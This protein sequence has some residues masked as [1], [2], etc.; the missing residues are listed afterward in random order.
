MQSM[1]MACMQQ[2]MYDVKGT[3]NNNVGGYYTFQLYYPVVL[4]PEVKEQSFTTQH[5]SF[6][7]HSSAL[8]IRR[9]LIDASPTDDFSSSAS[10]LVKLSCE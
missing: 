4:C 8:Q 6:N 10:R 5:F 2:C 3:I 9:H 7:G 1:R